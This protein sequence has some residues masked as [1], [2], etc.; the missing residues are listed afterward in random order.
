MRG[1]SISRMAPDNRRA[2]DQAPSDS[3][4]HW[5]TF[6]SPHQAHWLRRRF[7]VQ[8]QSR[9]SALH[10]PF[11]VSLCE[12][13][14]RAIR[15]PCNHRYFVSISPMCSLPQQP[16]LRPP[17]VRSEPAQELVRSSEFLSPP[18]RSGSNALDALATLELGETRHCLVRS[19]PI[20]RIDRAR[21]RLEPQ[22]GAPYRARTH[23]RCLQL[24]L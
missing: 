3:P 14:L 18:R 21:L 19:S 23:R 20:Q 6:D 15:C 7:P 4:L 11:F 17:A 2:T 1:C 22:L 12:V 9:S 24:P 10:P 8:S 5:P 13:R 16:Q